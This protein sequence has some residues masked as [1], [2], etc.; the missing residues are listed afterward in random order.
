MSSKHGTTY[1]KDVDFYL[2]DYNKVKW[3]DNSPQSGKRFSV[4][5]YE[6]ASYRV[7]D[8]KAEINANENKRLPKN[9]H[10][11]RI[12]RYD[13]APLNAGVKKTE[14]PVGDWTKQWGGVA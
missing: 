10:L 9:L 1:R 6:R 5:L 12:G 2:Y 7:M 4:V 13:P 11:R 3:S 14:A 8:Q